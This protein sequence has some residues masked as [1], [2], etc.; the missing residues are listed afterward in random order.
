M[1]P[2][3]DLGMLP[4]GRME[5]DLAGSSI[6]S[7]RSLSGITGAIDMSGGGLWTVRYS[8]V[9]VFGAPQHLYY[10]YLRNY[11]R[12]GVRS[13]IVPMLTDYVAPTPVA[14]GPLFVTTTFSDSSLFSDSSSFGQS[15]ISAAMEGAQAQNATTIQLK[16]IAG[17]L[18][19]G[20][21]TFS[22]DHLSPKW[23]RC[24]GISEIDS[25][26]TPDANGAIIY[27]VAITPPLRAAVADQTS[28]EFARPKCLMRLAAGGGGMPWAVQQY[29]QGL[30]DIQF[31]ESFQAT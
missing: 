13:I 25:V 24:Y 7:G 26:G 27:Q 16:I 9:M 17:G 10:Q 3:Y 5:I 29:W 14:G 19:Q 1:T 12:G 21:E 22:I 6:E 15:T 2:I 23:H 31:I 30:F 8:Q 20:G 18:L 11:L 28:L 4:P